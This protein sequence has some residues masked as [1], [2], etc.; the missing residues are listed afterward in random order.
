MPECDIECTGMGGAGFPFQHT[1]PAEIVVIRVPGFMCQDSALIDFADRQP[2][3]LRA[4]LL[5]GV[6]GDLPAC[7]LFEPGELGQL[8]FVHA[9]PSNAGKLR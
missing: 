4:I 7:G 8:P 9:L 6:L 5:T 2:N 3:G 1:V